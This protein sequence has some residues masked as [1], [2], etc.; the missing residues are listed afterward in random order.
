[1]NS[2]NL[3]FV[4][5]IMK[6]T[7]GKGV[8]IVLNSL[9]GDLLKKCVSVLSPFGRFLEIGKRDI[10]GNSKLDLLPFGQNL[11]FFAIDLDR[12]NGAYPKTSGKLFRKL[13]NLFYEKKLK[14][15]PRK[16]YSFTKVEEAF[17]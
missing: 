15:L 14:P 9:S 1:M 17:R 10:Y 4:G 8:D 16:V 13:M 3:D 12:L 2:R 6:K 5:D 11:S 7:N